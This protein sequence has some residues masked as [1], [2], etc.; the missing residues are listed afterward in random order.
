MS[1]RYYQDVYKRQAYNS[2]LQI[3]NIISS[4]D[5]ETRKECAILCSEASIKEAGEYFAPKL[6][7]NNTLP[8]RINFATCCYFTGIDIEDSYHL[9]TVSDVRRSHS[10]LT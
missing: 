5:E 4:L 7:D 1:T 3:R 9:I 10:M 8:A 6:G 2:I